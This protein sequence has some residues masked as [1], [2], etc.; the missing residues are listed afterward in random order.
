MVNASERSTNRS[1]VVFTGAKR[2]RGT[3]TAPAA[4]KH[5][6]AARR[7]GVRVGACG[8]VLVGVARAQCVEPRRELLS[9]K[10]HTQPPSLPANN[11]LTSIH[12]AR[13]THKQAGQRPAPL[14]MAVSSWNTG[15]LLLSR[16]LTV[17]LFLMSGSGSTPLEDASVSCVV[18]DMCV[19]CV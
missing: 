15:V 3:T 7:A 10:T 9:S 4:S 16:G 18:C 11:D 1:L 6:M 8:C 19:M 13:H 2:V 5:S 12:C 17:F 14:P